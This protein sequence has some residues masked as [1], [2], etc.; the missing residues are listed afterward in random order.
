MI[1]SR[2]ITFGKHVA[3]MGLKRN[4]YRDVVGNPDRRR[5][6]DPDV[7]GRIILK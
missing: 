5:I 6:E 3:R 7:D 4:A 2:R 1:K